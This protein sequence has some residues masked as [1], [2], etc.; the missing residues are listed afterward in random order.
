MNKKDDYVLMLFALLLL[1][2]SA[3]VIF[4][5]SGNKQDNNISQSAPKII[6]QAELTVDFGNG[7]K[8]VFEGEIIDGE[9]LLD[10]L[11]QASKAGN[12]SYKLDEKNNL[13]VIEDF[14]RNNNKS[15]HWYLNDKKIDKSLN[16]IILKSGDKI[17]IKY[18]Q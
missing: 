2:L 1:I 5:F 4:W 7:Q 16:E 13:A 6:G 18:A 14:I 11:N 9:T 10:A 12:F 15:W 8:R 3:S 17:L